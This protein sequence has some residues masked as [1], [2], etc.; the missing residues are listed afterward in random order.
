MKT[1]IIID[2]RIPYIHGLLDRVAEVEY[3]AY[4]EMTR[5]RL[6]DA[7]AIIIRTRT[8]CTRK[9]L[10]GTAVKLIVTATIG[11]DHIDLEYCKNHEITVRNA[12]GCNA[13]SVAQWF[14]EAIRVWR[15][16]NHGTNYKVGI[17]GLGHVGSRVKKVAERMGLQTMVCDPL[18]GYMTTLTEI[19]R[20]CRV[21]TFHTPLTTTGDYPTIGMASR[22]FFANVMPNAYIINAARGGIIVE[23]ELK[24][25]LKEHSEGR[26]AIDCW[27]NEPT[28]DRELLGMSLIGTPHIAG[29]SANGKWNGTKMSIEAVNVFFGLDAPLPEPLPATTVHQYDINID[30]KALKEAPDRFEWFRGHYPERRE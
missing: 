8:K 12:P 3:V 6:M 24:K 10:E 9:L 1:K 25:W 30:S 21:I 2:D 7:D 5:E 22:Q 27:E 13:S 14:G 17:V 11:M 23:N 19:G 4:E 20:Q 29:Y 26:C 15:D 16:E 28:I 18:K